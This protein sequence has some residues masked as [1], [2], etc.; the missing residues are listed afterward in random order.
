MSQ[1]KLPMTHSPTR[2]LVE[3]VRSEPEPVAA[4][5]FDVRQHELFA[6]DY[7]DTGDVCIFSR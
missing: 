7:P 2:R 3:E 1:P 5:H 6:Q 4:T